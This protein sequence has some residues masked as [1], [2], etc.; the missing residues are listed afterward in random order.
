M[1]MHA[2]AARA[3]RHRLRAPLGGQSVERG[4]ETHQPVGW[5]P[6]LLR[7]ADVIVATGA[8][9]AHVRRVHRGVLVGVFDNLVFAVAIGTQRRLGDAVSQRLAVYATAVLLYH[10]GM[11]HPASVRN[12]HPKSLRFGRDQFMGAAVAERAIG[13]AFVARLA[14][15]PVHAAGIIARL[16]R[17]AGDALRFGDAGRMRI[18]FVRVVTGVAGEVFVGALRQFLSLFVA[19]SALRGRRRFIGRLYC[20]GACP[21]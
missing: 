21:E 8:G 16:V 20:G 4:V 18:F 19:G 13:R 6:E 14:R 2:M 11:A 12:R 1:F 5:H 9:I 10:V 17:M 7:Q 3:I 15:Q